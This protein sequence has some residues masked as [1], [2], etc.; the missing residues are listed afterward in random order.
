MDDRSFAASSAESLVAQVSAWEAWSK[1]V[2]LRESWNKAQLTAVQ[3]RG[4]TKLRQVYRDPDRVVDCLT[5]LGCSSSF[6]PRSLSD[7]ERVRFDA[8]KR[9]VILISMVRFGF[10]EFHRFVRSHGVSKVSF[11]WVSRMP[12]DYVSWKL[13]A[14]I[15]AA[16]GC[17]R[18]A[19][20][21]L[22]GI[23]WGGL[24]HVEVLS[25]I[26]LC[27]VVSALRARGLRWDA[28]PARG[29]ALSA[30][31]GWFR[32]RGYSLLSP[33]KWSLGSSVTE[34]C[35]N[36]SM[37]PRVWAHKIRQGW[38]LLLYRKFLGSGRR[39]AGPEVVVDDSV[40][41][42][43]NWDRIRSDCASNTAMRNLVVGATFSPAALAHVPGMDSSCIWGCGSVGHH[44]HIAWECDKRPLKI[45]PKN[46][47][48]QRFGWFSSVARSWLSRIVTEVWK[49]RYRD[50]P[51]H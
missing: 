49:T 1:E 39:D 9:A 24:C 10:L 29:S 13:W 40:F 18:S 35:L 15:R 5:I 50:V 33:W 21:F 12:P 31:M 19:N 44:D 27:R 37:P 28:T 23:I 6:V 34:V 11:G 7:K 30:L 38:R 36:G 43:I 45:R 25:V 3:L 20:R 46:G 8:A 22:R 41:S 2:G 42:T 48:D 47:L 16:Q 32:S 14:V 26:Q 17:Q 4:K 51:E